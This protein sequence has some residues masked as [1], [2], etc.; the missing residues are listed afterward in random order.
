VPSA[1]IVDDEADVRFLI[2]RVLERVEGLTFAG[3]AS[4]GEEAI[5]RWRELRPD[6]IVLDHRMPGLS[7]LE[8]AKRILAEDPGQIIVLFTAYRDPAVE[9][10]AAALGIRACLSKTEASRLPEELLALCR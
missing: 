10:A 7:G 6:V 2:Y 4:S 9:Q 1:L 5:A 3:Q 8:T